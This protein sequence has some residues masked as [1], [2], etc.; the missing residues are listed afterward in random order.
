MKRIILSTVIT[1]FLFTACQ[2]EDAGA[3]TATNTSGKGGGPVVLAISPVPTV[4]TKKILAEQF[5]GTNVGATPEASFDLTAVAKSYPN[6]VYSAS[7]HVDDVMASNA[8]SHALKTLTTQP[9]SYPVGMIN[10]KPFNGN[11]FIDSKQFN[12]AVQ[13]LLNKPV[14][15]GLAIST[16][17][18][19]RSARIDVHAGFTATLTSSLEVH[20][21]LIEDGIISNNPDFEQAN[22]LNTTPGNM[23]YGAGNPIAGFEHKNVAR[24][25]LSAN[26]INGVNMVPGGEEVF[27]NWVDLPTMLS[28][29]S[30]YK[31]LSFIIDTNTQEVLNVQ[32]CVLG[33]EKDWN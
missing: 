6:N 7:L 14:D 3:P 25:L 30:T 17:I 33:Q 29:N 13:M 22:S 24:R 18:V 16:N 26:T 4:F 2:K 31:I 15:C 11:M 23:F 5:V 32:E 10:R 8:T 27:T 28:G 12:N 20:S 21:Y 9:L 19:G 1:G